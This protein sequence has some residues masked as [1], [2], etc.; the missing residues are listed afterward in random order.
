MFSVY[1]SEIVEWVLTAWGSYGDLS[2]EDMLA[3]NMLYPGT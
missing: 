2:I 1:V 3:A